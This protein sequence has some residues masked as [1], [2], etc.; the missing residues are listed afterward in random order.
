MHM[1]NKLTVILYTHNNESDISE[2]LKPFKFMQANI[3]AIDLQSSDSTVAQLQSFR[4]K[5]YSYPIVNVVEMARN[6]GVEKAETDWVFFIDADERMTP[7]LVQELN[8]IVKNPGDYTHF[9]VK[10]KEIFARRKWLEHGG[11]WPNYIIRLIHKPSFVDWPETIHSTPQV[12]GKV[13]YLNQPL[14]H[15]SQNDWTEIVD[16]TIRFEGEESDLLFA[17][18]RIVQTP[19]FFRKY[20]GELYRRLIRNKGFLDGQIGIIESIYQAFSKTIT[21]IFLYEKKKQSSKP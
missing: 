16:K 6:F 10:R 3:I 7:K 12:R 8:D 17:A 4:V 18:G 5:I 14:L 19:T 13:G 20:F 15:Y 11:W 2:L 9:K 21:Y 1:N